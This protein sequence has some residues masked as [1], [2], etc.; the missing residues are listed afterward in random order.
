[1]LEILLHLLFWK[2]AFPSLIGVTE[3]MNSWK[4]FPPELEMIHQKEIDDNVFQVI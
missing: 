1:M 4:A 3:K 2:I